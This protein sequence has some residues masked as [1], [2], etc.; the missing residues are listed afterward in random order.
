MDLQICQ[1]KVSPSS[2][3]CDPIREKKG[4]IYNDERGATQVPHNPQLVRCQTWT[5]CRRL[6]WMARRKHKQNSIKSK[7]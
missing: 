2:M 1:R 3:E 5:K 6:G 4:E 7:V